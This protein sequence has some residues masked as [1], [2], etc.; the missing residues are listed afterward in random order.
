MLMCVCVGA[1]RVRMRRF[2]TTRLLGAT[3]IIKN[4]NISLLI[5]R[6]L[7]SFY[8]LQFILRGLQ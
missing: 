4:T 7:Y 1:S 5:N 3:N 2:Y 6:M 8:K